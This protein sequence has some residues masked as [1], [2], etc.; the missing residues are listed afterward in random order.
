MKTPPVVQ[1]KRQ[2]WLSPVLALLLCWLNMLTMV[3]SSFALPVTHGTYTSPPAAHTVS[4]TVFDDYNQNGVQ[5]SRHPGMNGTSVTG[6]LRH[7]AV[8]SVQNTAIVV[9]SRD[10]NTKN[11]TTANTVLA[12][13]T[14]DAALAISHSGGNTCVPLGQSAS[15][16][17]TVS[18]V[19]G[20][21]P[22][23]TGPIT[24]SVTLP[25]D[26]SNA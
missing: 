8:S 17:L 21:S 23:A 24:I 19:S 25:T 22:I 16:T 1:R 15:Y 7:V 3:G 10:S 18:N 20:A 4:R 13:P 9:V 11:N 5:N 2:R 6:T 14:P 26:L 12:D